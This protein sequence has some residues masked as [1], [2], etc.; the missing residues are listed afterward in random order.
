M[1]RLSIIW[2]VYNSFMGQIFTLYHG[3]DARIVSMTKD[4]RNNFLSKTDLIISRLWD[5]FKP[6]YTEFVPRRIVRHGEVIDTFMRSIEQYKDDFYKIGKSYVYVNLTEKLSMLEA[7]YDG[8]GF[9]QYGSLYL[10]A[11]EDTAKDYARRSFAGGELGL[12]AYRLIEAMDV[13]QFPEWKP[14]TETKGLIEEFM[15]FAAE[16]KED[17]V[18]ITIAGID[19]DDLLTETGGSISGALDFLEKFGY[20]PDFKFRYKGELDLS[21]YPMEHLKK[22]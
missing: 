22:Q 9:Y 10:A 17:P 7:R 16:G 14:D 13:L 12:I 19:S 20:L 6:Y 11:V 8:S 1:G 2:R 4:E 21:S 15:D 18:V 5:V 3:T